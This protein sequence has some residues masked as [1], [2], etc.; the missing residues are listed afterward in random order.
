MY[1][2]TPKSIKNRIGTAQRKVDTPGVGWVSRGNP[3]R[4]KDDGVVRYR[5]TIDNPQALAVP[6]S[7]QRLP[8]DGYVSSP[9][10]SPPLH[11]GPWMKAP[12]STVSTVPAT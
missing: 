7:A 2:G 10:L 12:P 5:Y 8:A 1:W 4:T 9:W 6:V 11:A 3:V